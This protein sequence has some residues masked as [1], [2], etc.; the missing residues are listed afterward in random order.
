MSLPLADGNLYTVVRSIT[1][2]AGVSSHHL[3]VVW[4]TS[5]NLPLGSQDSGGDVPSNLWLSPRSWWDPTESADSCPPF[6]DTLSMFHEW[7]RLSSPLP[8]REP[9]DGQ[10][11]CDLRAPFPHQHGEDLINLLSPMTSV[12][13]SLYFHKDR[14]GISGSGHFFFSAAILRALVTAT[15]GSGA[16]ERCSSSPSPCPSHDQ[17]AHLV[18]TGRCCHPVSHNFH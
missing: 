17:E 18:C 14:G 16:L 1:A 8:A 4:G 7:T 10:S 6:T 5:P 12:I 3:R 11:P 2:S 15:L 13:A 9:R